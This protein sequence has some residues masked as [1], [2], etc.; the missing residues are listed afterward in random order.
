[1]KTQLTEMNDEEFD[2][3]LEYF[4]PDYAKD[5]SDNFMIPYEKALGVVQRFNGHFTSGQAELSRPAH[6]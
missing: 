2:Q 6:P 3:Y 4:I 5:L 1:M